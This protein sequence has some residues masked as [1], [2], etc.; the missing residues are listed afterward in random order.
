M[1]GV[2]VNGLIGGIWEGGGKWGFRRWN[3]SQPRNLFIDKTL[4][5][6]KTKIFNCMCQNRGKRLIRRVYC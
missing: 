2:R 6:F 4:I 1:G 3:K 5:S